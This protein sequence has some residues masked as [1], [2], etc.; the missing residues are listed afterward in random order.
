MVKTLQVNGMSCQHCVAHVKN[1]LTA[2]DGVQSA[3]V[4]L[5]KRTAV[6][7]LTKDVPDGQLL[8]AVTQAGYEPKMK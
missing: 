1:A 6:V 5:Q 8:D 3:E 7:T 4:D 2:V